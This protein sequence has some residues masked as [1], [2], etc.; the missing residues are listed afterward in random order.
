MNKFLKLFLILL[1]LVFITFSISCFNQ[2][3]RKE[4]A[5]ETKKTTDEKPEEQPKE[6]EG[7]TTVLEEE[8]LVESEECEEIDSLSNILQKASQAIVWLTFKLDKA[9]DESDS[10]FVEDG[11]TGVI[12]S[13]DGYIITSFTTSE[14]IEK[15]TV[16]LPDGTQLPGDLVGGDKNTTIAVIKINTQNMESLEFSTNED[17]NVG[18]A[19][20]SISKPFGREMDFSQG[21]VTATGQ[22]IT[23][24]PDTLPLVDL[25]KTDIEG[26]LGAGGGFLVNMEGS[27]IGINA[28]MV[29]SGDSEKFLSLAIPS[30]IATNIADQIISYGEAKIPDIGIEMGENNT[31]VVGVYIQSV[32]EGSPAEEAGLKSGDIIAE[33]NYKKIQTPYELLAQM[34]KHNVGDIVKLKLFKDEVYTTLDINLVEATQVKEQKESSVEEYPTPVG[35]VNDFAHII[36]EEYESQIEDLI[37]ELE[38]K[39][40]AEVAV[41]TIDSLEGKSI[42]EYAFGLFNAW[43]IGK[44]CK[45]NGILFLVSMKDRSFRIEVGFGLENVI[46]N[47][48]AKNIL[49]EIV[50]PNFQKGEFGR[51]SYECVEEI[52]KYI[53]EY[54]N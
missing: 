54:N 12:Y 6:A 38:D 32:V 49:D 26:K 43:G 30:S 3:S 7:E 24:S 4:T 50:M 34:L 14:D 39:T 47:E 10:S 1:C 33:F 51:G 42:E 20:I 40:T 41:V 36:D 11:N 45:D 29:R 44:A 18:E 37:K 52:S 5:I 8:P 48:I 46:T 15:I 27:L 25:I 31:A 22:S 19:V 23:M 9:E 17:V 28:I 13:K 2:A 21:F 35:N 16:T 53:L